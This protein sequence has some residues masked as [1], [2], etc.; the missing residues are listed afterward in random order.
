MASETALQPHVG[1]ESGLSPIEFR[2]HFPIF[3]KKLHLATNSKG[4]LSHEVTAAHE[5]YLASWRDHGSPWDA[6]VGRHEQL[7]LSFAEL[8]NARPS[9]VAVCFAA[10]QALGVLA[11]CLDFGRRPGVVFDEFSFPSVAQLWHAQARRGADVRQ[12]PPSGDELIE[13]AAFD[14]VLDES[15][16]VVSVAHGCYKNGHRLDLEAVG[17]KARAVDALF[18]VD[19]YQVCGTRVLD[20]QASGIDV[21]V[22][23]TL[24]F[25]LGSPGVALMYVREDCLDR[26]HP[27]LTGWFG[28]RPPG[29]LHIDHHEEAPD[30]TRFQNGTA[31]IPSVY[32]SYAGLELLKAVGA[33]AVERHVDSLTSLVM[34]RL[35]EAGFVPATPRDPARRGAVVAIR[36]K[37]MEAA[38][39]ELARRDIVVSS[40]DGNIRTAWHYYNTP[41]DVDVL[42]GVLEDLG[43]LMLRV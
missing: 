31:S 13:P 10:S 37:D 30:A 7:R 17:E 36:T 35:E 21:L 6:W 1:G 41:E 4:A 34:T 38:V 5:E 18:V 40:R 19:D 39:E 42:I 15:V 22:T 32:D 9:E 28:Q 16:Q 23:G 29:A 14:G 25:L 12:V 33:R 3:E 43:E 26:L 8:I 11:S 20:V 2:R 27:S 24:K